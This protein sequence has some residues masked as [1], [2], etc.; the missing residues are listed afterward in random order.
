M[1]KYPY[2]PCHV[3]WDCDRSECCFDPKIQVRVRWP[4]LVGQNGEKAKAVI[5]KDNALV[6]VILIK[7]GKEYGLPVFC[8]N[9][10]Y[11]YINDKDNVV[12]EPMVG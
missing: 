4:E 12:Q 10:V 9:R 2:P 6:T 8:C 1:T 11:V 7:V 5:E 3:V